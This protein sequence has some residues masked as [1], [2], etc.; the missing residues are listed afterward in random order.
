VRL[1]PTFRDEGLRAAIEARRRVP[2]LAV[3]AY[4]NE[5]G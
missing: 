3:L 1:P 5:V 4:L 2:E